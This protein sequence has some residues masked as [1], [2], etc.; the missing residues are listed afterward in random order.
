MFYIQLLNKKSI[1]G[2][3]HQ[4]V[5]NMKVVLYR[6]QKK[7]T[8]DNVAIPNVNELASL[9]DENTNDELT[10]QDFQLYNF[11]ITSTRGMVDEFSDVDD[12]SLLKEVEEGINWQQET[13]N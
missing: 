7:F 4:D 2:E 6:G 13:V 9:F 5:Q 8:V 1:L 11:R 3:H 12:E 10:V